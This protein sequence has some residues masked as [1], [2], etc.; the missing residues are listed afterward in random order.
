[1]SIVRTV[2]PL[3]NKAMYFDGM[4][5]YISIPDSPSLNPRTSI[6]IALWVYQA[7]RNPYDWTF[8]VAKAGWGS[9]HIISED[10]WPS[11]QVGFTVR[12]RGTDYRLRISK[13]IG[14]YWS[15][16]AFTYDGFTGEQKTYF[17][18]YIDTSASRTP[19]FI[20]TVAGSLYITGAKSYYFCGYMAQILI[21]KDRVLNEQEIRSLMNNP[22]NPIRDSLVLWLDARAC[23]TS[24][25]ICYDLSGNN[26]H[27]TMYNVQIVTLSNPVRVGG[28]L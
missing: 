9:Y 1:M 17:N 21:Y 12:V 18:G 2:Q 6:T 8:L 5:A 23:D 14:S 15:F 28:S 24:K 10:R 4:N 22:N 3:L 7:R 26:N 13:A 19:G 27:G 11:N 25:N 16:L 20:D